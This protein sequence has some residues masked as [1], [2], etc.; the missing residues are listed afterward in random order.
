[1]NMSI[2]KDKNWKDIGIF[3]AWIAGIL[4]MGGLLWFFSQ[5]IRNKLLMEQVNAVLALMERSPRLEETLPRSELPKTRVPLGSWYTLSGSSSRALVFAIMSEGIRFPC[6]ALVSEAGKV[7]EI[8][9]LAHKRTF[10]KGITAAYIR[11][12]E[13]DMQERL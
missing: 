9:P 4:L 7:D 5:P 2:L 13:R 12:I 11:R 6:V 10:P 8:I 1:M 3:A